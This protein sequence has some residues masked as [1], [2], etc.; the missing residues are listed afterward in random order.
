MRLAEQAARACARR[1]SRRDRSARLDVLQAEVDARQ[2]ESHADP[3]RGPRSTSRIRRCGRCCRCRARTPLTLEGSL[4]R[5]TELPL[6]RG[7]LK[8]PR[9]RGPICGRSRRSGRWRS[10]RW[11]I[12]NAECKPSL[13][14]ERQPA[15]SGRRAQPHVARPTTRATRSG[16]R[17][18]CRSLPRRTRQRGAPSRRRRCRQA[19]AR[20]DRGDSTAAARSGVGLDR[21]STPARRSRDDAAAR[22]WN[23]R[24]RACDRAGVVRERRD[25]VGRADGRTGQALLQRVVPDAGQVQRASS[26]RPRRGSRPGSESAHGDAHASVAT[27]DSREPLEQAAHRWRITAHLT[28]RS[29]LCMQRPEMLLVPGREFRPGVGVAR[30]RRDARAH[31]WLRRFPAEPTLEVAPVARPF[32]KP[33]RNASPT[34]VGSSMRS[35]GTAGTST[36]GRP[37]GSIDPSSPLRHD[38][39]SPCAR[40]A[41]AR[42]RPVFCRSSSNS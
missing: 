36:R 32:M 30:C 22:R 13:L 12:A 15:V 35:G 16:S 2:R 3:A 21:S 5:T 19:G 6:Q 33:P 28:A 4:E 10:N 18:G 25:H 7:A 17:C 20:P 11:R 9:P 38:Q 26:P 24:A 23:W 39:Q 1:D 40:P 27:A 14:S 37:S 34:P 41:R 29:A 31:T 42:S 8:Q